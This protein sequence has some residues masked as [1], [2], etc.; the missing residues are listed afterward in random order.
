MFFKFLDKI[1]VFVLFDSIFKYFFLFNLNVIKYFYV[2]ELEKWLMRL[3][4][5]NVS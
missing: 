1:L 2:I 4:R 3:N 5:R